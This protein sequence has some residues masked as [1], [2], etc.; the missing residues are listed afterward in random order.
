LNRPDAKDALAHAARRCLSYD[1][2]VSADSGSSPYAP[3]RSADQDGE[4]SRRWIAALASIALGPGA[5]HVAIGLWRRAAAWAGAYLAA[6]ALMIGAARASAT[7][8]AFVFGAIKYALIPVGVIAAFRAASVV[9]LAV[10]RWR[11]VVV[12]WM[13]CAVVIYG[14]SL[15][16]RAT[17]IEAFQIPAGSMMPTLLVGD[18]IFVG[19]PTGTIQRGDVVVF[20]FPRDRDVEYVKRVVGAGGDT[21]EVRGQTIH[22]NGVPVTLRSTGQRGETDPSFPTR[23]DL[24][25][26]SFGGPAHLI[27]AERPD[28]TM[29]P[30]HVPPGHVFVMGDNRDNS[31]DSRSWGT[32]PLDDVKGRVLFVW[33]SRAPDGPI[34]WD[35]IGAAVR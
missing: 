16:V 26:E 28:A 10:P 19:K 18:H 4:R 34:R 20:R 22:I 1:R 3:P 31:N 35:R 15:L 27:V 13:W 23:G 2:C 12:V 9:S 5:G 6:S 30:F 29:R 7:R 17:V 24:L 25:E 21:I 33:W 14:G 32:V 11:T 8:A